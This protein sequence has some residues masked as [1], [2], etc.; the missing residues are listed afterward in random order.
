M[1]KV[2]KKKAKMFLSNQNTGLNLPVL[3]EKKRFLTKQNFLPV[4]EQKPQDPFSGWEIQE[5]LDAIDEHD[6]GEFSKADLLYHA[7]TRDARI[8]PASRTRGSASCSYP[9]FL[10]IASDAPDRLKLYTKVLEKN[11]DLVL[12]KP[13]LAEISRR[14]TFLGFCVGRIQWTFI[15]GQSM[16]CI[17]PWSHSSVRYD[18]DK[19]C[20]A[21]KVIVGTGKEER[22]IEVQDDG[23]NWVIFSSGGRQPWLNGAIRM[24]ALMYY[25][26]TEG[27]GRWISWNEVQSTTLRAVYAPAIKRNSEEVKKLWELIRL[28]RSGDTMLLPEGFKLELLS[29]AANGH[30]TF[31]DIVDMANTN[32]SIILL[33]HNLSQELKGG[34]FAA[35]QSSLT[36]TKELSID[37]ANRTS[38]DINR[39]L[40][41]WVRAN[42][43]P[44]F[45]QTKKPLE[46]YAPVQRFETK[47]PE[48]R[49]KL[50][51]MAQRNAEALHKFIEAAGPEVVK[52]IDIDWQEQARRCGIVL[53]TDSKPAL[54]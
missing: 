19:G 42:F 23:V 35:M 14:R 10:E 31:A 43:N 24:L 30:A 28:L 21:A 20:Y 41:N 15:E 5:I 26:V 17:T 54:E 22:E 40:K 34:S 9:S 13:N 29:A 27:Y 18:W 39:V 4:T 44:I 36:V 25:I 52:M 45:Y 49:D 11:W 47:A 38:E 51:E 8:G 48:D 3:S 6:K 53:K 16:P 46:Y 32:I 37:D 50:S 1:Q 33:G 12:S 2:S 7:M